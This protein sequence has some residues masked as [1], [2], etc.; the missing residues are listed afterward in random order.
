[1]NSTPSPSSAAG[2]E[3]LDILQFVTS[4]HTKGESG[5]PCDTH[6]RLNYDKAMAEINRL[7]VLKSQITTQ[8]NAIYEAVMKKRP[9]DHQCI[10]HEEYDDACTVCS[11]VQARNRVLDEFS[12]SIAK[13]FNKESEG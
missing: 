5:K 9:I 6:I 12:Q 4:D 2:S 3:E 7:Y 10:A 11:A 1:M 8:N 13:I